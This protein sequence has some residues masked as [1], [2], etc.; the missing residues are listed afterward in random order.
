MSKQMFVGLINC[1]ISSGE[2]VYKINEEKVEVLMKCILVG[3]RE[4]KEV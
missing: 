4:K 3:N 1:G 2:H